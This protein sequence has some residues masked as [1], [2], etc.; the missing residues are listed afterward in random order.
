[1]VSS[2]G[3]VDGAAAGCLVFEFGG[4]RRPGLRV[5]GTRAELA[6]AGVGAEDAAVVR[7]GVGAEDGVAGADAAGAAAGASRFRAGTD[8]AV[9]LAV[10]AG[11]VCRSVAAAPA[12]PPTSSAATAAS[13]RLRIL[14]RTWTFR[15]GAVVRSRPPLGAFGT[16]VWGAGNLRVNSA[17]STRTWARCTSGYFAIAGSAVVL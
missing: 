9:G 17:I 12:T 1:V 4:E 8:T 13:I 10:S 15:G 6:A 11:A 2:L 5:T 14:R 7:A 3:F 16:S